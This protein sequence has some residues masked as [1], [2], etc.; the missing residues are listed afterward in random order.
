MGVPLFL[1]IIDQDKLLSIR[2]LP[3]KLIQNAE[4]SL[5]YLSFK[6]G[7]KIKRQKNRNDPW[8][9]LT[10]LLTIKGHF[11]SLLISNIFCDPHFHIIRYSIV[12]CLLTI[13]HNSKIP[14]P[15]SLTRIPFY[16]S[17]SSLAK[18][19]GLLTFDTRLLLLFDLNPNTPNCIFSSF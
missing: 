13:T 16:F 4:S 1:E 5:G 9:R 7:N 17:W 8:L 12:V 15:L 3:F 18:G 10:Y 6:K 11:C 2:K 14:I 19:E